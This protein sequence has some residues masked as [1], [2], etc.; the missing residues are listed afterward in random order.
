MLLLSLILINILE[1]G[2]KL[3]LDVVE[4]LVVVFMPV[5][6]FSVNGLELSIHI[7]LLSALTILDVQ[8]ESLKF[9]CESGN[10][11]TVAL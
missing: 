4:L 8:L 3:V 9:V 1:N 10:S 6:D 5:Y 11:V 2:A 7:I